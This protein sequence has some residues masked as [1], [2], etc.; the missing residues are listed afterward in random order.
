MNTCLFTLFVA[1][2]HY[3]ILGLN[4]ELEEKIAHITKLVQA[5]IEE[6]KQRK[7]QQGVLVEDPD[8]SMD[9]HESKNLIPVTLQSLLNSSKLGSKQDADTSDSLQIKILK[10]TII[11]I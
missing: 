7:R 5:E 4:Q 2:K 10:G 9:V 1:H 6:E 11:H 3:L 8:S